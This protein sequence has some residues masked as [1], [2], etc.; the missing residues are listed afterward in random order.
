MTRPPLA[1]LLTLIGVTAGCNS[2]PTRTIV[3]PRADVLLQAHTDTFY[4]VQDGRAWFKETTEGTKKASF[5][6]RA[7]QIELELDAY[8]RTGNPQQLEMFANLYRGFVGENGATWMENKYNDDIMWMVIA[9]ARGYLLTGRPEY[10]DTAKANFDLCYARAISPDL[11]GGLWWTTDNQSKNSCVNGPAAIAA[12]LLSRAWAEP[13]Y[14][15]KA[16]DLYR[17]ERATLFD[18]KTGRVS[19]NLNRNGRKSDTAFTYNE[20]TFVGAADLLDHPDDALLAATY[21]MNHVCRNGL[22]PQYGENDDSGGFNG[23]G[24]RWIARFMYERGQEA[25]LEPWLQKNAEAAWNAR[26][27]TDNL[28]W[29][30]WPDPT[31]EGRRSSFGC[32]SAVVLLQVVHPPAGK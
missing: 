8:E 22:L 18:P 25:V 5:W 14:R 12:V 16:A 28:S 30:R 7:E 32:S 3:S 29:C 10:R 2:A 31:P 20:G 21:T 23:V 24:V 26:R 15:A 4:Q 6:K 11:S 17:W 9:C 13:A 27:A 19:D 1:L